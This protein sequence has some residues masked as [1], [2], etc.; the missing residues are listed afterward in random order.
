MLRI[1][2]IYDGQKVV[3][4]EPV[5]LPANTAVEVIFADPAVEKEQA[6]WQRLIEQGL[7]KT[8]RPEQRAPRQAPA[9][10]SIA[11]EP[12]SETIIAERR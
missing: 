8:V 12:I 10:V 1:K 5:M 6:Y 11:G 2:G 3:L 7:V 9:P 4:S